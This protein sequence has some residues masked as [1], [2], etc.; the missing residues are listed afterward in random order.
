MEKTVNLKDPAI[1]LDEIGEAVGDHKGLHGCLG[2]AILIGHHVIMGIVAKKG[3]SRLS[4]ADSG[5]G[6]GK[7]EIIERRWRKGEGPRTGDHREKN[8]GTQRATHEVRKDWPSFVF[9]LF[10]HDPREERDWLSERESQANL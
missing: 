3:A 2:A 7:A 10:H 8:H 9:T 4:L 6:K 5:R 1:L